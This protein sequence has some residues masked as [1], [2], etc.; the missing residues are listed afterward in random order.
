VA[1]RTGSGF[2]S[3]EHSVRSIHR[4]AVRETIDST[5]VPHGKS[6]SRKRSHATGKKAKVHD[7]TTAFARVR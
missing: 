7:T 5:S 6:D 3:N 2:R 1:I 4:R